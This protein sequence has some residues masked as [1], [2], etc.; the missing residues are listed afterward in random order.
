MPQL[1]VSILFFF[2]NEKSVKS[3]GPS[4]AWNLDPNYY[5]NYQQHAFQ[6]V[7]VKC[8]F[9]PF[10]WWG[11][12]VITSPPSIESKSAV[13]VIKKESQVST[14]QIWDNWI[15][16]ILCPLYFAIWLPTKTNPMVC[17]F[18]LQSRSS[19]GQSQLIR[20][21][22]LWYYWH[23]RFILIFKFFKVIEVLLGGNG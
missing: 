3:K 9:S 6:A 19:L 15:N 10:N 12:N 2:P 21:Y 13:N 16:P 17:Y 8:R 14:A 4:K 20:D 23:L 11:H 22:V 1:I 5:Y 7:L 18:K